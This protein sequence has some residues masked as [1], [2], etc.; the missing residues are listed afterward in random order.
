L[1]IHGYPTGCGYPWI[2]PPIHIQ[3]DVV[4]AIHGYPTGCP[5]TAITAQVGHEI[6]L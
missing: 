6:S 5:S 1:D 3:L 2:L 4:R